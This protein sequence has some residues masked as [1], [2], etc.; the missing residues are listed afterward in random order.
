MAE[1][2][3]A[4]RW[5]ERRKGGEMAQQS[6]AARGKISAGDPAFDRVLGGGLPCDSLHI[7]AGPPGAGKTIMAQQIA[8]AAARA[9]SKVVYFTNVSE[10]HAKLV[11]HMRRF[12]FY[13]ADLVG[14]RIL[15]YN[16]TS[17]IR[18]KG[19]GDTLD[20]IVET[21]RSEKVDLVIVDSFRGLKH[22]LDVSIR[23][24]V[25]IFDLAAQLSILKCTSVLVGE[26]TPHETQT[27]PEFAIAD[28]I[29][30]LQHVSEGSRERRRL[31]V[32][33]MRGAAYL[34]GE[35]TM[36]ID[37]SGLRVYPRQETIAQAPMYRATDERVSIGL[38]GL[39]S[40]MH[41]GPIRSSSTLIA[42]SAG[43]GK[44]V[45]SLHFLAAGAGRDERGLMVSFQ[46]NPE[47]LALRAGQF[48][49]A[50]QLDIAGG[51]TEI[52]FLSPIELDLDIAAARIREAVESRKVKR[53][54]IDSVAELEFAAR[55]PE[56]FDDFLASLIGF[57]RGHEVTT[58]M[59]RELMQLF[60]NELNISS[61]GLFYIVDNI[62]LLRYLEIQAEIRRAIAVL[63]IR[64]SNHDKALRELLFTDGAVAVGERFT[65]LAGLMTGMPRADASQLAS[66][67]LQER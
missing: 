64:G 56:R 32:T 19:F 18:N 9:G 47:Q 39:D 28:G 48:G 26:Y 11:E 51:R 66:R 22:I 6:K 15:I 12:D 58:L 1:Q 14:D 54:V 43:A 55:D 57:L 42:G 20:F 45:L 62:V 13:E 41:G 38:A 5:N 2:S 8:F 40:M 49:L 63:K 59:T 53:V 10:P 16:I 46:E 50:E 31:R 37:S 52:L 23:E 44:T 34:G 61:R 17:Q 27:D 25:A 7:L 33:K 4:T 29:I 36:A 30:N 67:D 65:G 3:A 60:G 21:V 24:R 35:H